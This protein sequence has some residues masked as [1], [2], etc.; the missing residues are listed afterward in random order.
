MITKKYC[1]EENSGDIT[2]TFESNGTLCYI[3]GASGSNPVINVKIDA[4]DDLVSALGKLQASI[5]KTQ[6]EIETEGEEL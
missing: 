5:K 2:I 6:A 4:I 3:F 1:I